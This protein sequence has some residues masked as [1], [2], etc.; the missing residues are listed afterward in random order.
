MDK[1][2]LLLNSKYSHNF[3]IF[4]KNVNEVKQ[5]TLKIKLQ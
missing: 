1:L 5:D 3:K 4:I 2:N